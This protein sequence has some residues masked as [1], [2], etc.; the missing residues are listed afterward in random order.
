MP[1]ANSSEG[2]VSSGDDK[3]YWHRMR[4][5]AQKVVPQAPNDTK[6]LTATAA[7][8]D[9]QEPFNLD[10]AHRPHCGGD[11]RIVEAITKRQM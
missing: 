11:L 1:I 8:N 2:D 9:C 5:G 10:L 6:S 7:S 4:S 3:G